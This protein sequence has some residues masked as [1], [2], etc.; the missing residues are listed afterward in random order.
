[1]RKSYE[2]SL[3]SSMHTYSYIVYTLANYVYLPPAKDRRKRKKDS[4]GAI[5][6]HSISNTTLTTVI[7]VLLATCLCK[8]HMVIIIAMAK[9]YPRV[10]TATF[11]N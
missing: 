8:I 5:F 10:K 1:M 9:L 6:H 11:K 2:T 3:H 7:L 4:A